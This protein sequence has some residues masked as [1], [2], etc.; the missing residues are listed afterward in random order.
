[1][2]E[3]HENIPAEPVV[4]EQSASTACLKNAVHLL[5]FQPLA[6]IAKGDSFPLSSVS[7]QLHQSQNTCLFECL[8]RNAMLE[9]SDL[10]QF[11]HTQKNTWV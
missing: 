8:R 2:A 9:Q 3:T 5:F 10:L 4:F 11:T 1:M 6:V 7:T